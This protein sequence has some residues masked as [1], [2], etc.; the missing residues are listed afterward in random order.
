MLS[1]EAEGEPDPVPGASD[2]KEHRYR[3]TVSVRDSWRHRDRESLQ[4]HTRHRDQ[5]ATQTALPTGHS[6]THST[7]KQGTRRVMLHV[8]QFHLATDAE[9]HAAVK[10]PSCV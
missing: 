2:K 1:R 8:A 3:V 6:I 10:H 5:T 9:P 4:P 7:C